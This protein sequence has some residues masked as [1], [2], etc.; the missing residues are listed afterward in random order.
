MSLSRKYIMSLY[1]HIS[2]THTN[3][4]THTHTHLSG[5]VIYVA[6]L[7]FRIVIHQY[8]YNPNIWYISEKQIKVIKQMC[9]VLGER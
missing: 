3:K 8:R 9:K 5:L 7:E 2:H 1:K 6:D 4:Q